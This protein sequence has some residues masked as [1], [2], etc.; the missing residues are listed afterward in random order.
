MIGLPAGG[1]VPTMR[2]RLKHHLPHMVMLMCAPVLVIG[3][4][5]LATGASAVTLLPLAGCVLMMGAMMA[6]MA[7]MPGGRR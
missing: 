6:M 4:V 3:V 5:L 2:E 7:M 1:T